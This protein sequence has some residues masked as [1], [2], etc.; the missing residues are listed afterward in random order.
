MCD[1]SI[2]RVSISGKGKSLS[3]SLHVWFYVAHEKNPQG[4]SSRISGVLFGMWGANNGGTG[5]VGSWLGGLRRVS[6]KESQ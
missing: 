1:M 4:Q 3:K 5:R 2:S 6:Q